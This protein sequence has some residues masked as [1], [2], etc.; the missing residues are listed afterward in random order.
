MAAFALTHPATSANGSAA[1]HDEEDNVELK[2]MAVQPSI[3]LEEDIMQL[4][5]LG[6]VGAIQKLFDSKKFD[7]TYADEQNITP[8][9]V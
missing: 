9:H 8:L 7:A 3:P 2:E 4:A 6:E 5:R 1:A